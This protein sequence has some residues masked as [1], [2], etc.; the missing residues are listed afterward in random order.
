M[1]VPALIVAVLVTSPVFAQ[2][3]VAQL[4]GMIAADTVGAGFAPDVAEAI[5]TCFTSRMTEADA[6]AVLTSDDLTEQQRAL[7]AIPAYTEAVAC[8]AEEL[9]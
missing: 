9:Q 5:A 3:S 6:T 7:A 1:R 2:S 8:A 4:Q